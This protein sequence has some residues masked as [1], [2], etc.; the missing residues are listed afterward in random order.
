MEDAR[1]RVRVQLAFRHKI[2]HSSKEVLY[3]EEGNLIG[4]PKHVPSTSWEEYGSK[5]KIWI[6]QAKIRQDKVGL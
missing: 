6:E 3:D 2:L 5:T 4:M 1:I